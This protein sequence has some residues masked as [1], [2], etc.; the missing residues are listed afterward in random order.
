MTPDFCPIMGASPLRNYWLD[1]GWG[2]YGFKATA[3]A[4]KRLAETVATGKVPEILEPFRLDRFKSFDLINEI[5]SSL[6]AS[7]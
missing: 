1:V 2:T 5:S 6:G 7:H 4:G 3:V